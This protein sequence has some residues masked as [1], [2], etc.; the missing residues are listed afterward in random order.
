MAFFSELKAKL[1]TKL[2]GE[3]L[4]EIGSAPA[5]VHGST[6]TIAIRRRTNQS[7]HLHVK[8]AQGGNAEHLEI[9]C[10]AELADLME[11]TAH[12]IRKQLGS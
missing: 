9:T 5:S 8:T 1:T 6:L 2:M 7:P 12:E 4:A 3:L 11:K 10:S